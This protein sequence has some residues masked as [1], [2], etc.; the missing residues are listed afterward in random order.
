[1]KFMLYH[2]TEFFTRV[3]CAELLVVNATCS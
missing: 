2:L 1:M 3:M